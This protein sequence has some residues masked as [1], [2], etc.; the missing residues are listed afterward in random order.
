MYHLKIQCREAQ[1]QKNSDGRYKWAKKDGV[2]NQ[3][4]MALNKY[5][6]ECYPLRENNL[7]FVH[8]CSQ[9]WISFH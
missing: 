8:C 4:I 7:L 6:K 5:Y 1:L 9:K 2:R 3:N